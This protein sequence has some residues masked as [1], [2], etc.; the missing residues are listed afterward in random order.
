MAERRKEKNKEG[1]GKTDQKNTSGKSSRRHGKKDASRQPRT[2]KSY[3]FAWLY[4]LISGIIMVIAVVAACLI[5]FQV[6]N[7]TVEGSEKYSSEEIIEASGIEEGQNMFFIRRSA[8][9]EELTQSLPYLK[10]VSIHLT[11]PGTV[12]IEVTDCEPVAVLVVTNGY[13][14]ID[15]EGKLLELRSSDGGLPNVTGLSLETPTTGTEFSVDAAYKLKKTSLVD[16][17]TALKEQD[18]L[19]GVVSID[20][21]EGSEVLMQYTEKYT[22]KIPYGSDFDYKMRAMNGIIESLAEENDEESG[23]ID[24]TLDDEWHFIPD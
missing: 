24:L 17:L 12:R 13:W 23:V 14:F 9:E 6:E 22:V 8:I 5:F 1:R 2:R 7:V 19:D 16:L 11:L 20:L 4:G 3:R 10:T 15:E 21:S 18:L